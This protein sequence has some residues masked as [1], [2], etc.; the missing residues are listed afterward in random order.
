MNFILSLDTPAFEH[1]VEDV[2]Y[3]YAWTISTK[4]YI[5][6]DKYVTSLFYESAILTRMQF[7]KPSV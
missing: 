5:N 4:A 1:I 6:V 7:F 2:V 3:W